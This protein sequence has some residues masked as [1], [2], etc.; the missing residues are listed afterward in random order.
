[1]S[2]DSIDLIITILRGP[3][4]SGKSTRAQKICESMPRPI[5]RKRKGKA[6]YGKSP[7]VVCSADY[8]FTS[9][10]G[11]YCFD[12][13]RLPDAHAQCRSAF[14]DALKM[15]HV[16]RIVVDNTNMRMEH[17]M[18]YVDIARLSKR[19]F[20][21]EIETFRV[22]VEDDIKICCA[23]NTH[24]VPLFVIENQLKSFEE[25]PTDFDCVLINHK[26]EN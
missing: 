21:L 25:L 15:E 3:S 6:I 2:E 9:P 16:K 22:D 17:L 18:Q 20:K 1:M 4:G 10:S 24:S 7:V 14:Q 23:R 5:L 12:P 8:F 13:K 19:K 11:V 26:I